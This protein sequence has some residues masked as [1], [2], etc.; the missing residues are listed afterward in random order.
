[1]KWQHWRG[2]EQ[3]GVIWWDLRVAV[4]IHT[5]AVKGRKRKTGGDSCSDTGESAV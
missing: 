3:R 5:V 2:F 1:M 4:W